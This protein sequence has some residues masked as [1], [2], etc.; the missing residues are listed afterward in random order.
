MRIRIVICVTYNNARVF[1]PLAFIR[2]HAN[3]PVLVPPITTTNITLVA[4][5]GVDM[6]HQLSY[7]SPR[8]QCDGT[9]SRYRD[10]L[11]FRIAAV[12]CQYERVLE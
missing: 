3:F 7:E 5:L 10:I 6:A 4:T 11:E 2:K 9:S 12:M 1:G 8:L